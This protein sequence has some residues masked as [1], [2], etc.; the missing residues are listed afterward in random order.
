V[1][2][3][4][5]TPRQVSAPLAF[6]WS[7]FHQT[8]PQAVIDLQFRPWPSGNGGYHL[9][10]L[11]N[12]E[13]LEAHDVAVAAAAGVALEQGRRVQVI[14]DTSELLAVRMVPREP[15]PSPAPRPLDLVTQMALSLVVEDIAR[16]LYRAEVLQ[17]GSGAHGPVF[18]AAAGDV[19]ARHRAAA[20][21]A[22]RQTGAAR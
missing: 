22:V 21:A 1:Q 18:E 16:H 6:E 14:T 17:A 19:R 5:T 2:N 8:P 10:T 9:V 4:T 7:A 20:E 12:G 13:V 3:Q 15:G 11:E